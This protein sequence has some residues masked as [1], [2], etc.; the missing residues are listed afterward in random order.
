MRL[1]RFIGLGLSSLLVLSACSNDEKEEKEVVEEE[2]T[3]TA[4]NEEVTEEVKIDDETLQKVVDKSSDIDSYHTSLE[5][6]A[7][8]DGEVEEAMN[9]EVEYVD[10]NP[11]EI[12]LKSSDVLR[13][14]S[15]DG[16]TYF[17]NDEEWVEITDSIDE[18]ALFRVTYQK[19][20]NTLMTV[21][22]ELER[23]EVDGNY[24]YKFKGK[25]QNIYHAIEKLLHMNLGEIDVSNHDIELEF[26]VDED[27]FIRSLAFNIAIE[28][29]EGTVNL[30]GESIFDSFNEID[31][32]EV[33]DEIK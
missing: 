6:D 17:N 12:A 24:V 8:L 16:R 33:P 14:I 7:E 1:A 4:E 25:N 30:K 19:V 28:D 5:V 32:I 31:G 11:P 23:E 22:D 3:T 21:K 27:Y 9:V 2:T 20:V 29:E 10:G 15:K 18:G 26:V 13:T